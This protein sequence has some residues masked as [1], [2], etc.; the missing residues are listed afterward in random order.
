[1]AWIVRRI[2]GHQ[3]P[4]WRYVGQNKEFSDSLNLIKSNLLVAFTPIMQVIQPALNALA[5]G[6][7]VVSQQ[8]AAASAGMFGQTYAQAVEATKQMRSVS[9]AAKKASTTL[10]IDELNVVSQDKDDT[11]KADLVGA[12]HGQ[13]WRTPPDLA[14]ASRIY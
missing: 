13:I 1:M 4:D 8:I 14:N 12:G 3:I 5:S 7:A 11:G 10:S 9:D 2:P 6:F